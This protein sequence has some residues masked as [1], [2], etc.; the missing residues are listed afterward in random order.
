MSNRTCTID[1]C[2][3]PH[4]AKGLCL[5]H[6]HRKKAGRDLNS[7]VQGRFNTLEEAFKSRTVESPETGCLIWTGAKTST[8]YG[9]LGKGGK[10]YKAHR[11]AWERANGPIPDG[12]FVDHM[13]H[14]ALCVNV[15]HLRV[16][17]NGQNQQNRRG[18]VAGSKSGIRGVHWDEANDR[19]KA[20]VWMDGVQHLGGYFRDK[21]EAGRV[22][23]EMRSRLM[24][25]S[26]N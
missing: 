23:A 9:H 25:Y 2:A 11:Y 7:P 8:G 1:G 18:A 24:P 12:M 21:E 13:C 3:R 14:N 4:R 19:W 16:V 5:M 6:Y 26:Q 20:L 22:A 17:T 10:N 15:E